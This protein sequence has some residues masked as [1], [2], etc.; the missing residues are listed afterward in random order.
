MR[1]AR[2]TRAVP[3]V[4]DHVTRP[5]MRSERNTPARESEREREN[6]RKRTGKEKG[7]AR[8]PLSRYRTVSCRA[9]SRLP[10]NYSAQCQQTRWCSFAVRDV[11]TLTTENTVTVQRDLFK[12]LRRISRC[13]PFSPLRPRPVCTSVSNLILIRRAWID[14]LFSLF[15]FLISSLDS[16]YYRNERRARCRP[17]AAGTGNYSLRNRFR[18]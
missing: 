16:H 18:F 17:I 1:F 15:L 2:I 4:S 7:A 5:Y 8:V 11:S 10:W 13:S 12:G 6:G 14:F 3:I 9:Q